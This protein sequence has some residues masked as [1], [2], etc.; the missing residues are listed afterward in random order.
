[1][2]IVQDVGRKWK[3]L[4]RRL[5]RW[6]MNEA[7]QRVPGIG[8]HQLDRQISPRDF[9]ESRRREPLLAKT[10]RQLKQPPLPQP[11]DELLVARVRRGHSR[12]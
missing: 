1:M 8:S 5:Q 4:P 3:G 12:Q 6:V 7:M 10:F 2:S 9:I 11:G